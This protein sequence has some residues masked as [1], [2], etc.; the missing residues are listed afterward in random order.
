MKS[1][2]IAFL[3]RKPGYLELKGAIARTN[4]TFLEQIIIMCFWNLGRVDEELPHIHTYIFIFLYNKSIKNIK[5]YIFSLSYIFTFKTINQC[6][7]IKSCFAFD[8]F[9]ACAIY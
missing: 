3:Y 2:N 7:L 9:Y 8:Y 1:L 6:V 5:K 4:Q